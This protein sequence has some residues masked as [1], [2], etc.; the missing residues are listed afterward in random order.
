MKKIISGNLIAAITGGVFVLVPFIEA[1]TGEEITPTGSRGKAMI[2]LRDLIAESSSF[3]AGVGAEDAEEAKKHL[4]ITAC[5]PSEIT[6]PESGETTLVFE[7][8]YGLICRTENDKDKMIA[9]DESTVGGDLELRFEQEIPEEYKDNPKNAELNFLNWVEAVVAD[10]WTLSRLPGYFAIN[11]IDC[12]EGPTQIEYEGG[13]YIN[14]IRLL[15][16]WG[17]MS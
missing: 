10:M 3:Q 13:K 4:H 12:I 16:N 8:P 11:S 1:P 5:L 7:W 15:V 2:N 14:G 9:V 6:D 17:I